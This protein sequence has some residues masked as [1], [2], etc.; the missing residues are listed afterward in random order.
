[1]RTLIRRFI[2][3]KNYNI[4]TL[5]LSNP[6]RGKELEN[7]IIGGKNQ[8]PYLSNNFKG[9]SKI[10]V[11]GWGSQAPAQALN[12]RDSLGK[13][14]I[15]VSVGLRNNSESF[16]EARAN[17]F[18]ESNGTLGEMYSIISQSDLVLYLVSDYAQTQT[19]SDVFKA[20]KPGATLGLSHGFLLGYFDSLK[21]DF[22]DDINVVMVAPKGMGPS[23]RKNYLND[24]GINSSIAVHQ[25]VNDLAW[26]HAI[27]WAIGIGSPYI[28]ET[29]LKDE[30]ISDIFG[31]RGV[32]LGGIYG[33]TESLYRFFG[34][35]HNSEEAYCK[36]VKNITN[37]I[38]QM[39]SQNGLLTVYN[40]LSENDK[41]IFEKI[42][43][44]AYP[45][46]KELLQE[47]Y[48]EVKSGNEIRSV[49]MRSSRIEEY[50]I[51]NIDTTA[52]WKTE[53]MLRD[54]KLDIK[55]NPIT[56]GVYLAMMMAQ[57][58]VLIENNHSLSEIINETIIEAIDSLNPYLDEKGIS[59]MVDNCS[60]TARLGTRKWGSRFDYATQYILDNSNNSYDYISFHN[61][62]INHPIHDILNKLNKFRN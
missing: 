15:K 37:I 2:H 4:Q 43:S 8:Y 32:L 1:M 51:K 58:D 27:S 30:Y 53:K 13:S 45:V 25:N 36:S 29:T 6:I 17:G 7:L 26:D 16:D 60:T 5:N 49:I 23:L 39:I 50:P 57:I 54:K 9:V 14:N 55:L 33:M 47:I 19:Y 18:T 52:I 61:N 20:M 40:Y 46:Y 24:S 44:N 34:N 38:S 48:D 11:I 35:L 59:Y 62:F 31:E 41:L 42:Y 12:L 22:R 21:K 10:G 3:S 56:S 28:F